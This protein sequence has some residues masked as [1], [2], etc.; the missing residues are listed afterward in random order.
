MNKYLIYLG[1]TTKDIL[2][3]EADTCELSENANLYMFYKNTT[4][5][6]LIASVPSSTIFKKKE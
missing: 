4:K 6:E 3:I 5:R 1:N 2:E